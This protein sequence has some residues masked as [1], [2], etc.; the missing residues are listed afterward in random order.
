MATKVHNKLSERQKLVVV[1]ALAEFLSPTEVVEMVNS[2]YGINLSLTAVMH[3]D[4]RTAQGANLAAGLKEHFWKC[5]EKFRDD[6][7]NT[8]P[9]ANRVV[10]LRS[11]SQYVDKLAKGGNVLGAAEL[12]K[13]LAQ[14]EG[15]MFT[16]RREV[17]GPKGG[18]IPVSVESRPDLS[19]LTDDELR[20]LSAV[21]KTLALNS[22]DDS[23]RPAG[24]A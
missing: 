18:A 8:V 13:Q 16:N 2:Q 7:Y 11:L 6:M 4:P 3:Y 20:A 14:D 15:Q 5:R 21:S 10:R 24:A 22:G 17:S 9:Y 1:Q 23:G 12:L 19:K